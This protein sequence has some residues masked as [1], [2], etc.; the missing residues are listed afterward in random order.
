MPV[1]KMTSRAARILGMVA[2][3]ILAGGAPARGQ[4]VSH[5]SADAGVLYSFQPEATPPTT[6]PGFPQ[7]GVSGSA[8][9]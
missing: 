8:L 4:S 6:D 2:A 7:P 1:K 9:G 5:G 3:A